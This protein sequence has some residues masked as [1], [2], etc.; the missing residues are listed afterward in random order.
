MKILYFIVLWKKKTEINTF[1]VAIATRN[2]IVGTNERKR[3]TTCVFRKSLSRSIKVK[4]ELYLLFMF[5]PPKLSLRTKVYL[6]TFAYCFFYLNQPFNR[7]L[8]WIDFEKHYSVLP[9]VFYVPWSTL[10]FSYATFWHYQINL[11][12]HYVF[13]CF[14][15]RCLSKK[16]TL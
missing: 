14:C 4:V 8:I 10:P 13:L 15:Y 1:S 7:Q 2:N 6:L 11:T 3:R 12:F 9:I 16:N 5:S